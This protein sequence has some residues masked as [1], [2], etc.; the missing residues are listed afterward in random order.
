MY[1]CMYVCMYLFIYIYFLSN[2]YTQGGAL[3]HDPE[4]KNRMFHQLSWLCGG[5]V[6]AFYDCISMKYSISFKEGGNCEICN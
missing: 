6:S 5:P 1:V 4:M 3:T 2:L